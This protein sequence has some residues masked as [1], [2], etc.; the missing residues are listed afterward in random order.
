ASIPNFIDWRAQNQVYEEIAAWHGSGFNLTGLDEAQK[1][2]GG[3]VSASFFTTLGVTPARGRFF[4]PDEERLGA[5]PHVAIISH[6]LWT[7]TFGSDPRIVGRSVT[8][9]GE[10]TTIVGVLPDTFQWVLPSDILVP[11]VL[12]PAAN[13]SNHV[14][15]TM[16]RL[17]AG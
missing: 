3:A 1:V 16:G 13:R 2:D 14:L 10:A 5:D 11:L 4:V 6:G 9:N 12:D 15:I 17:R 7:R 8:I